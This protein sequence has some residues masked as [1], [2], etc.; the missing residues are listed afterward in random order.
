MRD[1]ASESFWLDDLAEEIVPRPRL[2]GGIEADVAIVG[3]GYTGLW[4][5]LYLLRE[6]P[7]LRVVLC[8]AGVAGAGASG[9]NGG[10]VMGLAEGVS[11]RLRDPATQEAG[12][13]WQRALFETVDEVGRVSGEEGIACDFAKGGMLQIAS[14]PAEQ[15]RL[16]AEIEEWRAQG[17]DDAD[18]RWLSPDELRGRFLGGAPLGALYC[19]HVA[20]IHPARLVR[21]LARAVET[22]GGRIFEGSPVRRVAERSLQTDAG[23]V[24]ARWVV[25]ATEGYTP[26]LPGRR[27]K[28]IPMHSMMIATEPLPPALWEEIGLSARETFGGAGRISTYGQ[29]TVSGRVAFGARGVYYYG[30]GVQERFAAEDPRFDEVHAALLHLMP[31]LEG[32]EVTHR[33]GGPLGVAR[34]WSPRIGLFPEQGLALAGGYV[35]EG[36]GASNLAGRTLADGILGRETERTALPWVTGDFP[37][38]EVEPLRWLGVSAVRRLGDHLDRVERA[39]RHVPRLA[40]ALWSAF[41]RH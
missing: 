2:T 34:D 29:R 17:F 40:Q 39:G 3:A 7:S 21:G 12:V 41:V 11:E 37:N 22:R 24:R 26:G 25:L 19:S 15:E 30:S 14:V 27:R 8:E 5:A 23:E 38:W 32:V 4:T 36:V 16:L 20:A 18:F 31:S 35:G 33:W 28:L 10:W 1:Y 13:R 6:D 9:R